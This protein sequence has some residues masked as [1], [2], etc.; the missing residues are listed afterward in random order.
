M[1]PLIAF[2][3][4]RVA[5]AGRVRSRKKALAAIL[6]HVEEQHGAIARLAVV[7]SDP[8]DLPEFLERLA[9]VY[10]GETMIARFG[11]VVG[12]HIGPNAIGVTYLVA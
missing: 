9:A 12:T 6:E 7:H 5:A 11:S 2:E 10:P 3:D 4:G 8:P 1:K